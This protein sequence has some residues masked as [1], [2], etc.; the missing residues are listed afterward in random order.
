MKDEDEDDEILIDYAP[1]MTS[2]SKAIVTPLPKARVTSFP[3]ATVSAYPKENLPSL[4][5][6]TGGN[7]WRESNIPNVCLYDPMSYTVR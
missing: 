3:K 2:H 7:K 5:I 1:L 6:T 4:E